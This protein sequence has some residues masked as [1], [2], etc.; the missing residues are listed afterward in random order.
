[1]K[2]VVFE[3]YGSADVLQLTEVDKPVPKAHEVLVKIHATTVTSGDVKIRRSDFPLLYWL[4]VRLIFGLTRPK[5]NIL[6]YELAGEI[7]AIGEKVSLFK[8]GDKIFGTTTGLPSGSYAEYVCLPEMWK[9]GV[10]GLMPDTLSFEEAAALPVGGMTALFLLRKGNVRS[11]QRVLIYGASGS[12]GT[13][14]VQ[15]AKH[16]GAE[17]TGVC[18]STNLELV[19]QLGADNVIDYLEENFT[20]NGVSYDLIF[21]A[22]GKASHPQV[23]K[24]LRKNGRYVSVKAMTSESTEDLLYLKKLAEAGELKAAIDR[25]YPLERTAEAHAYVETGRKKGNVVITVA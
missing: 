13:Y 7:E 14:A 10:I 5:R 4:P 2:A 25:R 6:G 3:T 18:S 17:V 20:Q 23:K 22:V 11:A 15:L 9:S 24:S 19:R 21:D 8:K 12:V 16:F 1:M